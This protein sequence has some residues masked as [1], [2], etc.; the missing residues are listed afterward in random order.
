MTVGKGMMHGLVPYRD[1]LEQKGP[2]LYFVYGLAA[3]VSPHS[4][5]SVYLLEL[6]A[7]TIALYVM[8][9]CADLHRKN[10]SLLSVP[11]FSLILFPV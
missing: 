8:S 7:D 10:T 9:M 2:V 4:F 11:L 6:I 5:F 3:L 1:L